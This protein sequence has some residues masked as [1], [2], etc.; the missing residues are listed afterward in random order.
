MIYTIK[1]SKEEKLSHPEPFQ[2]MNFK[3]PFSTHRIPKLSYYRYH[4]DLGAETFTLGNGIRVTLKHTNFENNTILIHVGIGCGLMDFKQTPYPGLPQLL[5]SAFVAGGLKQGSQTALNRCFVGKNI[6]LDFDVDEDCYAFKCQTDRN[7]LKQQLELIGA[8]L[9]EPG[10]RTEGET[11]F[12]KNLPWRYE[13]F[14]HKPNGVVASAVQDFLSGG[15][16]RYFF[17]PREILGK[18]NF[19]EAA[20]VLKPVFEKQ[21]MEITVIGD[22]DR[23]ALMKYLFATFGQLPSREKKK[24]LPKDS[25]NSYWPKSQTKTFLF[26]SDIDK[27]V[28]YAV[29]SIQPSEDPRETA[30]IDVLCGILENRLVKDIREQSGNT[31]APYASSYITETFGRGC[32]KAYVTTSSDKLEAVGAQIV[33]LADDMAD[34]GITREELD[35]AVKPLISALEKNRVT[36]DFW[37][38]FLKNA[39]A[40]P[41]KLKWHPSDEA[42]YRNIKPKDIQALAKRYLKRENA[43]CMLVKPRLGGEEKKAEEESN[44]KR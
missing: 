1:K 10:Y 32:V 44:G 21:Y 6:G 36:N 26:D 31:Y 9:L 29:W 20:S 27:A 4:P 35:R 11:K 41:E 3:S 24:I 2:T 23:D 30:K 13:E 16:T 5:S 42:R 38:E 8:Y 28:A 34:K 39:Q 22:F 25:G 43:V 18:R 19:V 17:P 15:D 14:A 33:R 40:R 12:R 37:M 7:N